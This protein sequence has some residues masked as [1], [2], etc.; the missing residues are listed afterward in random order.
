[1]DVLLNKNGELVLIGKTVVLQSAVRGSNPLLSTNRR[2]N[3]NEYLGFYQK[4]LNEA[5]NKVETKV[6]DDIYGD[7]ETALC[8]AFPIF[9]FG[10]GG[11]A[12]I[13]DHVVA[14]LTKCVT[15]DT[16]LN[17][18]IKSLVSNAPLLTCIAND[19]HYNSIFAKQLEWYKQPGAIA[20]GISSSGNS[21]NI[22]E[23]FHSAKL[24]N[25]KSI[26][27]VGFDGGQVLKEKLARHII[28]VP[29]NNY[30]IVEDAHMIILHAIVQKIRL[31]NSENPDKIKL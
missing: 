7:I 12:A 21:P 22:I 6:L 26:A 11:S 27:F 15:H 20:I 24:N 31:N 5:L 4:T 25:M 2:N 19:Y 1:M 29:A 30:G 10:N 13:A 14:D 16:C 8:L 17:P 3:M 9:L 23:A 28:H 18:V